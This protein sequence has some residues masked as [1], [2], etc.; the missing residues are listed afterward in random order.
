MKYTPL[1]ARTA[2]AIERYLKRE[3]NRMTELIRTGKGR[4]RGNAIESAM[5][6]I[7][8]GEKFAYQ[9]LLIQMRKAARRPK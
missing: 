1:E 3:I 6:A 2:D 4:R 8:L 7:M 5:K 9:T